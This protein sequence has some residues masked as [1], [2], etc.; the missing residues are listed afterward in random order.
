MKALAIG[1][2]SGTSLDGLDICLAEFE[3]TDQWTFKILKA[4]TLPYS[5]DWENKLRHSIHLSAEDLLELHTNY[6]FYLGSQVKDFVEKHHLE[7]ISLVASHGHTV[8]HQPKK[9]F[10]LQIGDG[11]AIRLETGLPV[12]YDFRSQD[13]LMNGNGAP[14]VPIGDELLFSEYSACLNLGGFSNISLQSNGRRIAFDIV[15]VNIVLN[16][17]AQ[18]LHKGFDENGDLARIGNIDE[19]LLQCLNSLDFYKKKHPKS[20]GIEWCNEHIFPLLQDTDP[21]DALATFTEHIATQISNV[22]NENEIKDIL[23][24]GGGAYNTF[25][26]E[27]IRT[28]TSS[29]LIIPEKEIIDFKEALIFAF[30][31]VLKMNNEVNVLASATGSKTDHC[32]GVIA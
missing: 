13:V 8:F 19:T 15:P 17:L 10:T 9:R 22:M 14:L 12:V 18:K 32:S 21:L 28:K 5:G 20:L 2:M 26:T 6:G 4:E 3:K 1:L 23:F 7:N 27:K 30:M 24:T 11:R 16:T 25:L 31:G 29:E